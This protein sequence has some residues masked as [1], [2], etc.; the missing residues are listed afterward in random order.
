MD[1]MAVFNNTDIKSSYLKSRLKPS[2]SVKSKWHV[3]YGPHAV[4]A[5]I[6]EGKNGGLCVRHFD[7]KDCCFMNFMPKLPRYQLSTMLRRIAKFISQQTLCQI[8]VLP[9]FARLIW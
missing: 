9:F 8:T 7:I 1:A 5:H 3:Q 4:L 6:F 2:F